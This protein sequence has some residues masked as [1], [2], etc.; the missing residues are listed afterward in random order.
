[1]LQTALGFD[2]LVTD[3]HMPGRLDGPM[4]WRSRACSTRSIRK[5]QFYT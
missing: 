3:I 1:L 2:A 4:G 5:A